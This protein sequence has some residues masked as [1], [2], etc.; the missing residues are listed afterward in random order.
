MFPPKAD[1]DQEE[2]NM[3]TLI[4]LFFLYQNFLPLP[5]SWGFWSYWAEGGDSIGNL[6]TFPM[7]YNQ[8]IAKLRIVL[9]IDRIETGV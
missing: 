1:D 2:T 3:L 4:F 9:G 7:I 5:S 6:G 8:A